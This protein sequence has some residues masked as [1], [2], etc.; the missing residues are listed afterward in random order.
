MM[1][2]NLLAIRGVGDG[3]TVERHAAKIGRR[4]EIISLKDRI[5]RNFRYELTVAFRYRRKYYVYTKN[6][7]GIKAIEN[8][9]EVDKQKFELH[10]KEKAIERKIKRNIAEYILSATA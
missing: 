1:K 4:I 7:D 5:V 6:D 8:I 9:V 2:T 3:L 10:N